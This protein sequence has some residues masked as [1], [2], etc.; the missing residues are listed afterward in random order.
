MRGWCLALSAVVGLP[1]LSLGQMPARGGPSPL[2]YVRFADAG[3]KVTFYSGAGQGR[4]FTAPVSVGLRPG[5]IYRVKIANLPGHPRVAL[6]PTLEVRG[7]LQ[8]P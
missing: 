3:S 8:L 1:L 7:T 6:Y 5:Y 2:L 4:E